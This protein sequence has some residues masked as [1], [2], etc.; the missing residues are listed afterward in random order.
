MQHRPN[1]GADNPTTSAPS[2]EWPVIDKIPLGLEP[3]P[4]PKGTG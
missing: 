3:Y 1:C 4:P 2:L